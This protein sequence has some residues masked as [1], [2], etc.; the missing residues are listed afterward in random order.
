MT[1]EGQQ[2][3]EQ[4]LAVGSPAVATPEP[5]RVLVGSPLGPLAIDL[6]AETVTRL[7]ISPP[8]KEQKLYL[9]LAKIKR[10]DALDETIG[11]LSEYFAGV[12]RN[13]EIEF[14]L[15]YSGLDSFARRVLKE[16]VRV[17]YGKTRTYQMLAEA[18]GRPDSYRQVL[19]ILQA[20]PIPVLVPCHRVVAK[21]S[22]GSY[23]GGTR[24]KQWLL[25]L[26]SEAATPSA[27]AASSAPTGG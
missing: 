25:R 14:D 8:V 11:R 18:C 22:L 4:E 19:S 26:E 20:N 1:P 7:V 27:S 17:P 24:K 12:R 5:L 9:P 23:I 10:N 21:S 13:P 15:S 16:T 3:V 6:V 2:R